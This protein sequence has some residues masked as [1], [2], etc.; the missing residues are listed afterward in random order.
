MPTNSIDFK[1]I[2]K[3]EGGSQLK[4]YVPA[5]AKSKSGA[6][7]A[8]GFDLGARS[9]VDIDK[10]NITAILKKKLKSYAGLKK[11]AAV[12]Y[13]KLNP[14][15]ITITEASSID[16]AVKKTVTNSLIKRYNQS[17]L[18][19]GKTKF[20]GLPKQAQTVIASVSYQYG[21]LSTEAPK[22]WKKVIIQDWAGAVKI[23]NNFGD[24]YPTR[25]KKEAKLLKKAIIVIT[26]TTKP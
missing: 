12:K 17:A 14:L 19:K 10:L 16:K 13:L 4:G 7:I 25:R 9:T 11:L 6:T 18:N 24:A 3:L 23:L 1:F 22:F 26:N 5:A 21:A 15:T 8:T 2:S 20:K